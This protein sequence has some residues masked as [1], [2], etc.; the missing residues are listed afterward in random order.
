MSELRSR[1]AWRALPKRYEDLRGPQ[2][3]D[4]LFHRYAG[5]HGPVVPI[6]RFGA[7]APGAEVLERFGITPEQ[8]VR[9]ARESLERGRERIVASPA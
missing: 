6:E 2:L 3:R 7:S 5:P 8:A 9:A 4:H 1:P